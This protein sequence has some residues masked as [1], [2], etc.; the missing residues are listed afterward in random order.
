M[1]GEP[2][3]RHVP[4]IAPLACRRGHRKICQLLDRQPF[5]ILRLRLEIGC[6]LLCEQHEP[7]NAHSHGETPPKR[8]PQRHARSSHQME[9][10]GSSN[11]TAAKGRRYA[12]R[13]AAQS[14]SRS[15]GQQ[16]MIRGGECRRGACA[17]AV[18]AYDRADA[19]RVAVEREQTT[20]RQGLAC[21]HEIEIP[22]SEG[23]RRRSQSPRLSGR[24]LR[25]HAANRRRRP[26]GTRTS[27]LVDDPECERRARSRRR[28]S[29]PSAAWA[30]GALSAARRRRSRNAGAPSGSTST[31]RRRGMLARTPFI[32]FE[33]V[34]GSGD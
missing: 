23:D 32:R 28:S 12:E 5:Q 8:S 34:R 27:V 21:E 20:G 25:T 7:L 13:S 18:S 14:S 24:P 4:T 30:S 22:I 19:V 16:L 15:S 9:H 2:R 29:V 10:R 11:L 1:T 3:R 26:D 31:R 17:S 33:T 6:G